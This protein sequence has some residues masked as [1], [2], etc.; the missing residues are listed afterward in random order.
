MTF[1]AAFT[2]MF[3]DVH[4]AMDEVVASLPDEAL[5]WVPY[6]GTNSIAILVTHVLGNQLET[7]RSVRS[8]PSDR[9]RA[10][11]FTLKEATQAGLLAKLEEA[12]TVMA[13]LAPQITAD[14]LET[15]VRR[16]S[17]D[18]AYSGMHQ[19]MHSVAH[20]REHLGQMWIT[21]DLWRARSEG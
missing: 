12:R 3:G 20:A 17:A 15:L 2:Q 14:E 10:A 18:A 16:P 9:D 1:Q 4:V 19:L 13:E 7:L 5:N 11:E 21:R 6:D 8:M